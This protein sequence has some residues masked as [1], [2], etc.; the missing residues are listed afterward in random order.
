MVSRTS[1]GRLKYNEFILTLLWQDTHQNLIMPTRLTFCLILV[2]KKRKNMTR[3]GFEPTISRSEVDRANHYFKSKQ[4]YSCNIHC[5]ETKS[6]SWPV[7]VLVSVVQIFFLFV[8]FTWSKELSDKWI[9]LK[10]NLCQKKP[11]GTWQ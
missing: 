9:F 10:Q 6:E 2:K 4:I 8:D 1:C 11:K 5:D 3:L 7:K